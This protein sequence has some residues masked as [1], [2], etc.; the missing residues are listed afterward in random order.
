MLK[1]INKQFENED[2]QKC[3][4]DF[5]NI[6]QKY[7]YSKNIEWL[8]IQA[9][10]YPTD[11]FALQDILWETKPECVIAT[12][13]AKGGTLLFLST[14]M[15]VYEEKPLII[16]ID[17]TVTDVDEQNIY[18]HK[19]GK[20]IRIL[21]YSSID[22]MATN[23]ATE[24]IARE[25]KKRIMVFLDSVHNTDYV[26]KEISTWQQ[27]VTPGCYLIVGWTIIDECVESLYEKRAWGRQNNPL[28]AV[29]WFLSSHDSFE[30]NEFYQKK[31]LTMTTG[32]GF[33]KR[34]K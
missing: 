14:I 16:G 33:L 10:Q 27:F 11:M 2:L 26:C 20:G 24:I 15:S 4:M 25:D 28:K 13:V 3:T 8:G 1:N 6:T 34:I 23:I 7:D 5:M 12:G 21:K 18:S 32:K 31:Y 9:M 22:S 17:P 30:K 29:E 19:M